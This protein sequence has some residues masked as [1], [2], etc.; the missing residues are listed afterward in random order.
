M[1]DRYTEPSMGLSLGAKSAA[2]SARS[3]EVRPPS[4]LDELRDNAERAAN[5]AG[6]VKARLSEVLD[7]LV[8]PQPQPGEQRVGNVLNQTGF[9]P[10]TAVALD[11]IHVELTDMEDLLGRLNSLV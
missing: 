8:G 9:V 4:S 2:M 7:R 3:S 1:E 10:G 5:R 6:S 11:R